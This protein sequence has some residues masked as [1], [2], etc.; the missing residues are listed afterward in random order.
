[1]V[2]ALACP[3]SL[4]MARSLSPGPES[5]TTSDSSVESVVEQEVLKQSAHR[6][7]RIMFF[8]SAMIVH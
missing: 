1:M 2:V 3:I 5:D 4:P 7:G 6:N 8:L